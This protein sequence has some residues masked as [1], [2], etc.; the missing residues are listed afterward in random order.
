MKVYI[1]PNISKKQRNIHHLIC[2]NSSFIV[3]QFIIVAVLLAGAICANADRKQVVD[4]ATWGS[5][6]PHGPALVNQWSLNAG[7]GG[8]NGGW[9][10]GPALEVDGGHGGEWA[11]NGIGIDGAGKGHDGYVILIHKAVH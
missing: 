10:H 8:W 9:G 3:L 6:G 1:R 2:S 7:I 4:V 11:G 5:H